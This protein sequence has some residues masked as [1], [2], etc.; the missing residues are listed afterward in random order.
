MET[1]R[2][3][4]TTALATLAASGPAGAQTPGETPVPF[5]EVSGTAQV[6]VPADRARIRFA[7]ETRAPTAAEAT[8]QNADR[9]DAVVGA[10]RGLDL[11]GARLETS[12]Y[13]LTPVYRRPERGGE[14]QVIDA[15][16][17][18]NHVELTVD[19]VDA[20]GRALDAGIEAGA[21]RVAGLSFEARDTDEARLEAVRAAVAKARQEAQAM[22]GALG[23]PLGPPLEVRGG[24]QVPTPPRPV[25]YMRM[26]AAME[27]AAPTPVEPGEQT[28]TAS[29]TIKY[30]LQVE[31]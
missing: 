2:L 30:R 13:Q 3:L 27:Q 4:V 29:V 1:R 26:D 28:V 6:S 31:R 23:L 11:E 19:D 18:L 12:G 15:Y 8:G 24:A 21:N 16:R 7:V 5:L 22:A 14:Q 9:M 25:A 10:L 17:A 20:V